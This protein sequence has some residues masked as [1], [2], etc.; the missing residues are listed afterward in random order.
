MYI[1]VQ[2][3]C[4]QAWGSGVLSGLE[5]GFNIITFVVTVIFLRGRRK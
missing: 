5:F 4:G 1:S 2:M 3:S